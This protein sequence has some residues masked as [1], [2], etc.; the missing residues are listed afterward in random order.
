[1]SAQ[2]ATPVV[3]ELIV[4][5]IAGRDSMLLNLS[6]AHGPFFTRN[7]VLLTDSDGHTG[8]GEVPGGEAI[9]KTIEDARPLVEGKAI[10]GLGSV[11]H[12]IQ[13]AFAERDAGGRGLQTFDLR[14]TIHAATAIE[15]AMYDLLGQHTGDPVAAILSDGEPRTHV[16]MLGYL[17]YVGDRRKTNLAYREEP[18]ATDDWSRLRHEEALTPQAIVRLAQAAFERYG[19][20][21]FKLKGGVLRGEQEIE[22]IAALA[23]AFP[24]ARVTLDPNGAWS[25]KEAIA[26]CKPCLLYTSDAADE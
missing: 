3:T 16:E 23:K 18:D 5:P 9:R 4:I 6:G 10:G 1:M 22:A 19:F 11:V 20:N 12:S 15:A 25:L 21:D 13:E 7:I 26:L 17:F 8:L 14:T 2:N 24:K